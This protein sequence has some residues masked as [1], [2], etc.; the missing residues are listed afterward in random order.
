[1][2]VLYISVLQINFGACECGLVYDDYLLLCL[3]T[4]N[5]SLK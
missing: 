5:A 1:M 4:L 3:S 2:L